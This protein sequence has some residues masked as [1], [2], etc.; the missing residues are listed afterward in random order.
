M[1][2]IKYK[3]KN[4]KLTVSTI[5]YGRFCSTVSLSIKVQL[6]SHLK[7]DHFLDWRSIFYKNSNKIKTICLTLNF[8]LSKIFLPIINTLKIIWTF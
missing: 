3:C 2:L 7:M 4:H 6:K 5:Q 1:Y 8:F